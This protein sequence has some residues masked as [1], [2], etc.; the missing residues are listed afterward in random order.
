[1]SQNKTKIQGLD[2]AEARGGANGGYA[3][4]GGSD[5]FYSR[6]N[7]KNGTYVPGMGGPR[8][9][10]SSYDANGTQY[11]SGEPQ[12][13][14]VGSGKPMVG[15][16]YSVSRT[17]MGEFW[18]L[19]IGKN[20]IGQRPSSDVFLPEATVSG[21][22]A[23]IVLRQVKDGIIAAIT[24]STSTNGTKINGEIIGFQPVECHN[25]DII[26]IG[27]S[28]ELLFILIDADRLN[29]KVAEDFAAIDIEAEED[30]APFFPGGGNTNPGAY[31]PTGNPAAW[32]TTSMY[33]PG[34][35]VGLD[36]GMAGGRKGGT[37]PDGT[38]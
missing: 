5:S 6:G 2:A 3:Q 26:T 34:G 19:Q 36:G 27:N 29:L 12:R 25:G 33:S 11:M 20:T 7:A 24:D 35:T 22:H 9:Q 15:F 32:G 10:K 18:P 1:M 13:K 37:V 38:L 14:T 17:A 16:L 28:Y 31:D 21:D 30:P 23:V 8:Q 4:G